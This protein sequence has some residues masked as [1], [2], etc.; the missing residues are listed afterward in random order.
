[1]VFIKAILKKLGLLKLY[2]YIKSFFRRHSFSLLNIEST[3]PIHTPGSAG[4][5][6]T[7]SSLT[8]DNINSTLKSLAF[9]TNNDTADKG[10]LSFFNLDRKYQSTE[11]LKM[12]F[13]YFGSDKS[14]FHDYHKLYG[15]ILDDLNYPYLIFEIGLGTNNVDIASNMGRL[16]K[17]G[18]SLRAFR[19]SFPNAMIYGADFDKRILFNED[20]IS[21]FF[22]DQ[23]SPLTFESLYENIPDEFDLMIDDGLHSIS[24]NLNSLKFFMTKIRVGGYIVIEDIKI[25]T[26]DLWDVVH[27]LLKPNYESILFQTKA[28]YVFVAKRVK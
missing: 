24:A 28:A 21:T 2:Y 14:N 4:T 8:I 26:Q 11:T 9:L 15:R 3:F 12:K 13:D 25:Q 7:I 5:Y 27:N 20:R 10:L 1:M 18:A 19:E 6:K 16:G 23:T 22:V 17:P